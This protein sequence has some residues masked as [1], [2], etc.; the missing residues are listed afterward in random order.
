MNTLIH[1]DDDMFCGNIA[2]YEACGRQFA[3]FVEQASRCVKSGGKK[4][5]LELPCGYGRVTRHLVEMFPPADIVVADAMPQAVEFCCEQFGV[6]GIEVKAPL[7]EL[8]DVPEGEFQVA[9]MGSLITHLDEHS[10]GIVLCCFL[11]KLA[12][13]GVAVITTH[14]KRA[15]EIL[16]SN[17]AWFELL[18]GDRDSLKEAARQGKYGYA[19]YA[20]HHEFERKTVEA[21]GESYGISLI[22]HEWMLCSFAKLGVGVIDYLEG[23]WDGHQDVYFVGKTAC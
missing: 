22:P 5:I 13:G 19:R 11:S 9:A 3:G 23:G 12:V 4:K 8:R 16:F 10:A 21:V 1:P 15:Q 7:N 2:H 14:G 17:T 20:P 18:A 6:S